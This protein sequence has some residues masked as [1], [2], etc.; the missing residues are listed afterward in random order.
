[1]VTTSGS[2]LLLVRSGMTEWDRLGRVQGSADLPLCDAGRAEIDQRA[3]DLAG[4]KL[5]TLY[6]APD[7]ASRETARIIAKATGARV[8]VEAGL[9]EMHLGLWEGLLC[10]ALEAKCKAGKVFLEDGQGV[11]P[12]GGTESLDQYRS[13]LLPVMNG[14]V[15]RR[16]VNVGVVLRPIALGVVRCALG[17]VGLEAFWEMVRTRPATEWYEMGRHDQRMQTDVQ[18]SDTVRHGSRKSVTAA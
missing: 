6:A 2:R 9:G 14:L 10:S 12:P 5:S 4:T 17:G 8:V 15:T 3:G 16:K 13:R 11:I 18:V 7:E 1:M